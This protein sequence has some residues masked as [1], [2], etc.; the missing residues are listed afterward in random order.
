MLDKEEPKEEK[1]INPFVHNATLNTPKTDTIKEEKA[2][3]KE[4]DIFIELPDD[5]RKVMMVWQ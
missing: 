5:E 3:V 4:D 2:D 1:V